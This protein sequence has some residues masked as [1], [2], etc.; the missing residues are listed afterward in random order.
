MSPSRACSLLAALLAT[1]CAVLSARAAAIEA[2]D[3]TGNTVR[4]AAPA[5]R[6]VSLA[7]NVTEMLFAAGAGDSIVGAVEYSDYPEAAKSVPRVGGHSGYDIERIL[8]LK[9]DLV[10]AWVGG[11]PSAQL[12][13]LKALGLVVYVSNPRGLEDIANEIER[14]GELSGKQDPARRAAVMFRARLAQLR[15][16]HAGRSPVRVFYQVWNQPLMT[17]N[18]DDLISKAITL[19][20]GV[21]VF[22]ALPILAPRVD[23]EA[24]LAADPGAIV[25]G[26]DGNAR[27]VWLDEWRRWPQLRA[28]RH[29]NLFHIPPD[30]MQRHGPR[31]LDGAERLCGMLETARARSA[32]VKP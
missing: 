32:D 6:I 16:R 14:L 9:P 27:P 8:A 13:K 26:G 28:V 24:V 29:G 20:G 1:V 22:A 30:I 5:R 25:A 17:V 31:I 2:I 12:E 10:V 18:G 11:N 19:C 21:N 7:P 3:G 4:L 15:V 23:V